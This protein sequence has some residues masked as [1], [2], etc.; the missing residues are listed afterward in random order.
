VI[1]PKGE[2]DEEWDEQNKDPPKDCAESPPST[3]SASS[4]SEIWS[5]KGSMDE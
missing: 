3:T 2:S 1:G 4:S 5:R